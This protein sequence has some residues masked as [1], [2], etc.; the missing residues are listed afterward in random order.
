MTEFWQTTFPIPGRNEIMARNAESAG[1]DGIVFPDTQC[2]A[3]DIYSAMCLAAKA[4]TTLKIG[5]AVT[6]PVT[7][8]AAVTASA[9]STVQ[10]ESGGRTLLGVGRGDS[11]LG[12]LG[13]SP[14]P[15]GQLETYVRQVQQYLSGDAVDL[16]GYPSRIEWLTEEH[17]EAFPKPPVDIAATGPRVIS[18]G[19]RLADR[20]TFA[21]G[22]D[23]ERLAGAMAS[24][25]NIRAEAGLDPDTI[26]FGA[27]INI[28]CADDVAEACGILRGSVGTFAHF[29]GMSKANSEGLEDASV[30]DSIGANY[31]MARHAHVDASHMQNVPDDFISRFAIT[32]S[33]QYCIDR[34][35]EITD[36]G[37]GRFVLLTGSRG[38]DPGATM[39]SQQRL[40]EA[41]FPAFR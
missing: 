36:L 3:G 23:T 14:A 29:T 20:L 2:L 41:V 21:V 16:D 40:V 12:Y 35:G 15:V 25:R 32:G 18:V 38:A 27:Y 6:N 9:I 19:A 26:D 33:A 7:R 37:I 31:D 30:F 28:A 24:A 1:W 13:R 11:S 10:V 8:H 4:T 5:T 39:A 34:L 22:A 17:L